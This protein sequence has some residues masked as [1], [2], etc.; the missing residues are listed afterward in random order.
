MRGVRYHNKRLVLVIGVVVVAN[1]QE[2]CI[3]TLPKSLLN[4]V[5][6]HEKNLRD[7]G[8]STH[9]KLFIAFRTGPKRF[10]RIIFPKWLILSITKRVFSILDVYGC[11]LISYKGTSKT[12][13]VCVCGLRR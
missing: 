10:L 7:S 6:G 11:S 4:G 1:L 2:K 3:I 8:K 12:G 9:F 13:F 5:F